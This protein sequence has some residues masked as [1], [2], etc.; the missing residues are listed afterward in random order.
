[1]PDDKPQPPI[2]FSH[3][4]IRQIL[5]HLVSA[6]MLAGKA[7]YQVM[8]LAF[9]SIGGSWERLYHG[10][11]AELERLKTIVTAWGKLPGRRY[12]EEV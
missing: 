1:M 6:E 11:I 3:Q 9:R 5:D 4:V 7:D 10:D 2:V 12:Q 8:R